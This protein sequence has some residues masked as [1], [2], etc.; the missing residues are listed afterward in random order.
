MS[1]QSE[2]QNNEVAKQWME[3]VSFA[4]LQWFNL[5]TLYSDVELRSVLHNGVCLDT[6]T[7]LLSVVTLSA[8]LL[9][10]TSNRLATFN[11]GH[12]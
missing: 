1:N 10:T 4:D 5:S 12:K 7:P 9:L 6:V 2:M 8:R 3:N 11:H